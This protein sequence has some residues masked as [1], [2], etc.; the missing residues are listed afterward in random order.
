MR[1]CDS[2]SGDKLHYALRE[3]QL[4]GKVPEEIKTEFEL[5]SRPK[6]EPRKVYLAPSSWR[7]L[8]QKKLCTWGVY[9]HHT[10]VNYREAYT[11]F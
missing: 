11:D 4:T 10:H 2:L 9:S 8:T 1:Y 6:G 5:H 3:V 7:D